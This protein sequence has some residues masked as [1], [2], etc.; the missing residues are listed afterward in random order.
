MKEMAST[1]SEIVLTMALSVRW[2]ASLTIILSTT[3]S[4]APMLVVISA[5][6]SVTTVAVEMDALET[7][8]EVVVVAVVALA[9]A[10]GVD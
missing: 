4:A 6:V 2:S 9:G 7:V 10:D 5:A 1:I 3:K 8:L